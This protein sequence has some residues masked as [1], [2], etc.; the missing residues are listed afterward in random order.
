MKHFFHPI[1]RHRRLGFTLVELMISVVLVLLLVAAIARIFGTTSDTIGQSEAVTRATAGLES[2]RT[3][4]QIDFTGTD[5]IAA[6]TQPSDYDS[7]MMPIP[8]EGT[9]RSQFLNGVSP[10]PA[11][12]LY[13]S[14]V[15]TFLNEEAAELEAATAE[16]SLPNPFEYETATAPG[17]AMYTIDVDDD[18][19]AGE[20][21][22][23]GEIQSRFEYG[24]RSFRTDT[25]SFFT[26]GSFVAQTN[27]LG[28]QG[29]LTDPV[30]ST[31]AWVWYGHGRKYNGL[32]DDATGTIP[33]FHLQPGFD[34]AGTAGEN[35]N[36]RFASEFTLVRGQSLLLAPYEFDPSFPVSPTDAEQNPIIHV[37]ADWWDTQGNETWDDWTDG[38]NGELIDGGTGGNPQMQPLTQGS[39]PRLVENPSP[40]APSYI[41][42]NGPAPG[43]GGSFDNIDGR[44][45]VFG[46]NALTFFDRTL[47]I[48]SEDRASGNLYN[49]F[50][51]DTDPNENPWYD[52]MFSV[53]QFNNTDITERPQRIWT[54]PVIRSP[55]TQDQVARR[56][57]ILLDGATQ[58]IVEYAGDYLTQEDN[59]TQANYGQI[60]AAAPD[61][62]IDFVL[63]QL[64]G[65]TVRETRFYGL[66]RDI[67]GNDFIAGPAGTPAGVD[68]FRFDADVRPLADYTP[69]PNSGYPFERL[70]P[71]PRDGSGVSRDR[72][73]IVDYLALARDG[74][75]DAAGVNEP[76]NTEEYERQWS[77]YFCAW[78]PMEIGHMVFLTAAPYDVDGTGG[79]AGTGGSGGTEAVVDRNYV[80]PYAAYNGVNVPAGAA[81]PVVESLAPQL[82]RVI[83]E[84]VDERGRLDEPLRMELVFRVPHV[85]N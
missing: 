21:G 48:Q 6:E 15:G 12:I 53:T 79:T 82:F 10:Q 43:A 16:D 78:G 49:S 51:F 24:R 38:T 41:K 52:E 44:A 70:L 60:T 55:V 57:N 17:P 65:V 13:S 42:P 39:R 27:L 67:D 61:G 66:P 81:G 23:D 50:L 76:G 37:R 19:V 35:T 46:I 3:S 40:T 84:A 26:D 7:G 30:G 54:N 9:D 62:V 32:G 28:N 71:G 8:G 56:A 29:D 73:N 11:I 5:Q 4:L 36:N 18:G 75:G 69:N 59:P 47:A 80:G 74:D 63:R 68:F 77:Q 33:G 64:G 85:T 1:S 22:V 83:V 2:V 34:Q 25:F 58:F 14:R 72:E 20:A 31:E 45:N